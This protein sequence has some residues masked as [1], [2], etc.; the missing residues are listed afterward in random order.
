MLVTSGTG[1]RLT[2][3]GLELDLASSVSGLDNIPVSITVLL[4]LNLRPYLLKYW[5]RDDA[6]T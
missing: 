6:Q 3:L 1:R 2:M 5:V 4:N